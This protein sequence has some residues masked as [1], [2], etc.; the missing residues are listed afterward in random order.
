MIPFF[1]KNWPKKIALSP[2]TG[3]DLLDNCTLRLSKKSRYIRLSFNHKKGLSLT[4]PI[5]LSDR[6][7]LLHLEKNRGWLDNLRKKIQNHYE[8]Y[9]LLSHI[10]QINEIH[11]PAVGAFFSASCQQE[12]N[13]WQWHI[14]SDQNK[15]YLKS[16]ADNMDGCR[17]IIQQWL[18]TQA[19]YLLM[20]LFREYAVSKNIIDV[21]VCW[22]VMSSRWGS[23]SSR[24][25]INLNSKLLFLPKDL[26]IYVFA[27]ELAHLKHM[28]HGPDFYQELGRQIP[29]YLSTEKKLKIMQKQLPGWL[30]LL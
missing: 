6:Q 11:F 4:S 30:G 12:N 14:F 18:N 9:D 24:G 19:K 20:P 26:V 29:D 23:C 2:Q 1:S 10:S 28:N 5:K 13:L 27:H 17:K 21:P 8:H 7:V 15:W 16:Q 22:K 25:N 3:L